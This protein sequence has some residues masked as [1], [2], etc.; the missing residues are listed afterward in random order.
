M[1]IK[2]GT[3]LSNEG[4]QPLEVYFL[5]TG[6]VR[7]KSSTDLLPHYFIEGAMF[8]EKDILQGKKSSETYT[9][10][11]DCY[12]LSL[13]RSVFFNLMEEFE[14][15]KEEVLAIAKAREKIRIKQQF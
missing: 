12:L 10:M 9:A 4:G 6:C 15:F 7:L 1:R 5:L 14:D 11:C 13:N 8:G 3:V 2:S